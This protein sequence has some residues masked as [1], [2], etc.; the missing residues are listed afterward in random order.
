MIIIISSL[1]LFLAY[2]II[3]LLIKL[4]FK[5][6]SNRY[7]Q[8]SNFLT[9]YALL[10]L[11]SAF[12]FINPSISDNIINWGIDILNQKNSLAISHVASELTIIS[13]ALYL[14][15]SLSICYA[16]YISYC[17]REKKSFKE[18]FI[19][20]NNKVK[21]IKEI[22]FPKNEFQE[23]PH[24]K[25]RLKKY[26]ELKYQKYNLILKTANKEQILYGEYKDG[27]RTFYLF[28]SYE[29]R[30]IDEIITAEYCKTTKPFLEEFGK[31]IIPK[32]HYE[33]SLID[34]YFIISNGKF[35]NP[36]VKNYFT[37]TED[38]ILNELIDF[39]SY[40]KN[41]VN[42][43]NH[44]KLFSAIA[45]EKDRKTLA[46]T[47][48]SPPFSVNEDD[49]SS[50]SLENHMDNWLSNSSDSKHLVLL[51][52]YGM[53]KTSFLRH[54]TKLLATSILN[55][56][57]LVRY[58]VLISLTNSSPRHGGIDEKIKAF[59]ADN[60]GVD[61]ALFEILIHKGK[62]LFLLDGFDEM[63]FVGTH[64]DR[65]KQINEI[66]QLAHK[67]NKLII[68]GRPS[69][70]PSKYELYKILNIVT[71]ED[72]VIQ[73]NPYC[74]SL[75]L[76]LLHESQIQEYI[77]KYYPGKGLF[78]FNWI[79]QFPSILELCKRPSMMHI[80]REMLPNMHKRGNTNIQTHGA[81]IEQ[82]IDYWI[83]RQQSKNIQ[84][85]FDNHVKKRAFVKSFFSELAVELFL[86]KQY[87]L[88][89]EYVLDKLDSHIKNSNIKKFE[90]DYQKEGFE[91]E[92]LTCYFIEIEDGYYRF[93]HESFF[94]FFVAKDILEKISKSKFSSPIL[95]EAWSNSIV[96]F[97]YDDIPEGL[98]KDDLVP[99]LLLVTHKKWLGNIKSKIYK[100]LLQHSDNII[101]ITL[102]T[103]LI[104]SVTLYF[105]YFNYSLVW[106]FVLLIPFIVLFLF[107]VVFISLSIDE[108]LKSNKKIQ[109]I[110]KAF[111][112][113]FIKE[114]FDKKKNLNIVLHL[115]KIKT[116]PHIPIEDIDI[117][118]R[119]FHSCSFYRLKNVRFTSCKFT[120][121]IIS[122]CHLNSVEFNKTSFTPIIFSNCRFTN[123]NFLNCIFNNN[124][125]EKKSILSSK[126]KESVIDFR[127]CKLD[128][129]SISNLKQ[130][131]ISKDLK[132]GVDITGSKRF[133]DQMK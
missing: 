119:S 100:F 79:T 46:E 36:S 44:D 129:I 47:F 20:N 23:S 85:A 69:Y 16:L 107:I 68:S 27:Y 75:N 35:D 5:V 114:Q 49:E 60:L 104:T 77:E 116:L 93:V 128:N 38:D 31:K 120:T 6:Q 80:I 72:Q 82:Y 127:N 57:S 88:S 11:Y 30:E 10:L 96:N 22:N 113:A 3:R 12:C 29:D 40:L 43:Y 55:Q 18:S 111:K 126:E 39:K 24:L 8:K 133:L 109:F 25:V 121:P 124:G 66:W 33:N 65:F 4:Y 73:T 102:L 110:T 50:S 15:F 92:I 14:I 125:K 2:L 9:K 58:P 32:E 42:G 37:K 94:E 97:I 86:A 28:I 87:H 1:F 76:N 41:I 103:A 83:N 84:S 17:K 81:A 89:P 34:Y 62:I 106:K 108:W 131:I 90:A 70:F 45:S 95:F 48:I 123:V 53:G 115:L 118:D 98:K 99:A 56:G 61:Y 51:G 101:S 130:L 13:L 71:K 19:Y 112:I 132:L 122:N 64:D 26:F 78:Y 67:N 105:Y 91:N 117:E 59:V 7:N 21:E 63:G 54:Y 74:E 52:D